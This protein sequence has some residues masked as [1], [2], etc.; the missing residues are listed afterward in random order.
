MQKCTVQTDELYKKANKR[1]WKKKKKTTVLS[2]VTYYVQSNNNNTILL[3]IFFSNFESISFLFKKSLKVSKE[4][5][6]W[7]CN[8]LWNYSGTSYFSLRYQRCKIKIGYIVRSIHQR[9]VKSNKDAS[10]TSCTLKK[11]KKR[12]LKT[13]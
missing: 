12:A 5:V 2:N 4:T 7:H 13:T 8:H 10:N 9:Q 6:C 11:P 3:L 1:A